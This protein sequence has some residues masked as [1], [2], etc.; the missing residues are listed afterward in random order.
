MKIQLG[1]IYMN[2]TKKYLVPCL[3]HYGKDFSDRLNN[4]FKLAC[5]IGDFALTDMGVELEKHVFILIDT[6]FSRKFFKS[7]MEWLRTKDYYETDYP[8]D[9][10]HRG[11]LHMLVIKLPE[12]YYD[13][14]GKFKEGQFSSMYSYEDL[15]KFFINQSDEF[16]VLTKDK[17]HI[18][19]FVGKVNEIFATDMDPDEWT[20]EA[21]FPIRT[22][23]EVFNLGMTDEFTNLNIEI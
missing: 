17:D 20:G 2:R 8:F 11:H 19:K 12:Q 1:N 5:G 4:L 22:H 10:I 15:N 13:T 21:D 6:K 14:F 9:D 23:Q 18:I 7:T 16:K 3:L